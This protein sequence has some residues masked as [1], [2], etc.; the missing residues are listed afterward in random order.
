[1]KLPRLAVA[2]ARAALELAS[3]QVPKDIVDEVS[4]RE[5]DGRR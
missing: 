3:A 1:V 4:G 5:A 2:L